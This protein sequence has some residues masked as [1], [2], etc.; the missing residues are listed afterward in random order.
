MPVKT[1]NSALTVAIFSLAFAAC[2]K[3]SPT[4]NTST[5]TW[6]TVFSDDFNRADSSIGANYSVQIQPA[7]GSGVAGAVSISNHRA[8]MAGGSFYAIRYATG[9]ANAVVK[10]SVKCFLATAPSSSYGMAVTAKSRNL[11]PP[12]STPWMNQEGYMAGIWL[13][14]IP[15]STYTATIPDSTA[16]IIRVSG[17]GL[18][19]AL[20]SQAYAVKKGGSYLLELTANGNILTFVVTDLTTNAS[21]TMTVTDPGAALPGTILSINGMQSTGDTTYFDDFKIEKYE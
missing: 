10:V 4:G 2:N 17:V 1:I 11:S 5:A 19:P 12:D 7:Y 3:S 21:Q 6:Q 9:I 13:K 8:R 20:A 15:A 16:G 18:P 14:G